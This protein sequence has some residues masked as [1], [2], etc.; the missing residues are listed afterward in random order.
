MITY[1][2]IETGELQWICMEAVVVY[3][4]IKIQHM[5]GGSEEKILSLY[6]TSVSTVTSNTSG[7]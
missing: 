7:L 3:L 1:V 6:K 2:T 5:N 4:K